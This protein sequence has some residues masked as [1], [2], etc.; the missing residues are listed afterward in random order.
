[1]QVT[2]RSSDLDLAASPQA[3]GKRLQRR[4]GQLPVAVCGGVRGKAQQ[5]V[6]PA[7]HL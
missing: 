7:G 5:V 4:R 6:Q 3:V 2:Y 1:M